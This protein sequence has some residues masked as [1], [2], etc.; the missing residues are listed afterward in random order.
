M[1]PSY[2]KKLNIRAILNMPTKTSSTFLGHLLLPN[3]HSSEY[4]YT[5][6]S[7]SQL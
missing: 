3:R 7:L 6:E 5:M 4:I 1:I 2:T